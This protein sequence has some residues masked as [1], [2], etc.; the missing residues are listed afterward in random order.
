MGDKSVT[1]GKESRCWWSSTSSKNVGAERV[2]K[3]R[4][5][6]YEAQIGINRRHRGSAVTSRGA[7]IR[8]YRA[9]R[10]DRR[11]WRHDDE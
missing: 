7:S 1:C 6:C 3:E 2:F 4:V 9:V 11:Q 8:G 5:N 10:N